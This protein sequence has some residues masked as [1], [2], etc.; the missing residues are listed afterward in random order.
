[1]GA[2]DLVHILGTAGGQDIQAF[3]DLAVAAGSQVILATVDFVVDLVTL[4]SVVY[5]GTRGSVGNLD[6]QASVVTQDSPLNQGTP[7]T[8]V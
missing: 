6:I 7:G 2:A 3:Q 4:A 5:R 8:A 1:V